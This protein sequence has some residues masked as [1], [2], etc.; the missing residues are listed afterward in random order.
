LIGVF[1]AVFPSL[2]SAACPMAP[3]PLLI[4]V[5][6]GGYTPPTANIVQHRGVTWKFG[7]GGGSGPWSATD[8]T[9]MNLFDTGLHFPFDSGGFL[10]E[11]AG[12][13]PYWSSNDHS[14]VGHI[15][16]ALKRAPAT[17]HLA[18]IYT[19]TWTCV[20]RAGFVYDI[21]N[22]RPGTIVWAAWKTGQTVF[23]GKP[24]FTRKGTFSF[25]SRMRQLS[26]GFATG[27]SAAVT[28]KV[29]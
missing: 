20:A 4:P 16:V 15:N 25:R 1:G 28:I 18:T 19:V 10:F 26:T 6:D 29:T 2:A 8:S 22:K 3:P 23:S 17:G 5:G 12:S 27:Y 14:L 21:Q 24:K 7:L 13:Y 9:G 11:A